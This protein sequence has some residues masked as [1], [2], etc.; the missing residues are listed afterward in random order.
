MKKLVLIIL[1]LNICANGFSQNAYMGNSL[2]ATLPCSITTN[3]VSQ[4]N[5]SCF[6]GNNGSVTISA[7]NGTGPYT[8]SW[9]PTGG[10]S[11]TAS[12]LSPGTY[13][14]LVKDANLCASTRTILITQPTQLA[15]ASSSFTNVSCFGGSDGKAKVLVNGGTQ[16]Y[17]YSWT[18]SIASSSTA[19]NLSA[20][21]YSCLVK[22]ANNCS[23]ITSFN[24]TCP[25]PLFSN[26]MA[27]PAT[28]GLS[29]GSATVIIG[30]GTPT[31]SVNWNTVPPQ[32]GTLAINMAPGIYIANTTDSKGCS[33]TQTIAI[34]SQPNS[35]ITGF[36]VT[37]PACF[38][39][40]N[41]NIAVNYSASTPPYTLTWSS[42][43]SQ[44]TTSSAL[45]QSLSGVAS[46]VFTATLTDGNGCVTS[47]PVNV[48]Q[49]NAITAIPS[50]TNVSCFGGLNGSASVLASGGVGGYTYTWSPS[51]GNSN[52]ATNLISGTY[53]CLIKDA[54]NC[55]K[56]QLFTISQ[57]T[58]T[59]IDNTTNLVGGTFSSNQFG[60]SYQ[61]I[62]CGTGNSNVSGAINQTFTPVLNGSYAVTVTYNGCTETSS[63]TTISNV[64][65]EEYQLINHVSVSPNPSTGQ[66]NFT[67]LIGD[68]TI[69][70]TD[71]TGRVLL[72]EKSNTDHYILKLDAAQGIYFYKITDKQN[73]VQQGKLIIN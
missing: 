28:C 46:G 8:Y 53:T 45:T 71:I 29:N 18:P 33:Y 41:G 40:S 37:Q 57:S 26:Y 49:P 36:S 67:G 17:T 63:C 15:S 52:T 73:R 43:I 19:V 24:I 62:N 55:T 20:G 58:T 7:S 54:N 23:L 42:P 5:V 4:N 51:G 72:I 47:Q 10:T 32:Q 56:L 65:I 50:Q 27:T 30:G 48:T 61:W 66:F 44:T 69:Q 21:S 1:S 25:P 64:G 13:T 16:P 9:T 35:I 12:N 31:Y 59:I 3:I 22:D 34:A 38:G 6:G 39:L 68:N 11:A 70:I 2:N 14:C 60:A